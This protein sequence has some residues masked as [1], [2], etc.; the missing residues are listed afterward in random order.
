M[1]A[2]L[3]SHVAREAHFGVGAVLLII[4]GLGGA[5]SGELEGRLWKNEQL[6]DCSCC[7]QVS[8]VGFG[9][10]IDF[11]EGAGKN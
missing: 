6:A 4:D 11:T 7:E 1:A 9:V 5:C 2:L 8:K 3:R 10:A